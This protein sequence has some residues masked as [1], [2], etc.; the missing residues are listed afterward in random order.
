MLTIIVVVTSTYYF[1][2][3]VNENFS[4]IFEAL[5]SITI[6]LCSG[7]EDRT[8]ITPQG[9]VCAAVGLILGPLIFAAITAWMAAVIIHWGK[10]M[11]SNLKDHYVVLNWNQRALKVIDEIRN[12]LNSQENGGEQAA[13]V[14]VTDNLNIKETLGARTNGKVFEGVFVRR[15]RGRSS[16]LSWLCLRLL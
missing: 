15:R 7:L 2:H 10:K 1:E 9:R 5:W 6:Y 12:P 11:P 8:L 14:V 13:V 3:E 4:T 16:C